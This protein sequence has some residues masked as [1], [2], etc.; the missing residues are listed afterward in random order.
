METTN[1]S[2]GDAG[3]PRRPLKLVFGKERRTEVAS[4]EPTSE[5]QGVI[6]AA[7]RISRT[8]RVLKAPTAFIPAPAAAGSGGKRRR[9]GKKATSINCAECG[10]GHSPSNNPIVLC[11][12]CESAWHKH[13]HNPQIPNGAIQNLDTEWKCNHCEPSQRSG[14]KAKFVK[15]KLVKMKLAKDPK[16][17]HK[18][19]PNSTTSAR[20]EVAGNDFTD[21]EKRAWLSGLSHSLLV[22]M[23]VDISSKNPSLPIFPANMKELPLCK[24]A[25]PSARPL[26][27]QS[28]PPSEKRT[29]DGAT[30]ID[31]RLS[32][33]R[34]N[35]AVPVATLDSM[36]SPNQQWSSSDTADESFLPTNMSGGQF[37]QDPEHS[38]TPALS[39]DAPSPYEAEL[40]TDSEG[41][42]IPFDDHRV[43]PKP[44][45][46]FALLSDPADLDILSED[47]ETKTFSHALH[48]SVARRVTGN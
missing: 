18:A 30:A 40:L 36:S 20:I 37:T 4:S 16:P 24:F 11:D 32:R 48:V 45:N 43:Y 35:S 33:T 42:D 39:S 21:T 1:I 26:S 46:G 22:E 38:T 41:G 14:I 28:A 10:R 12:G 13:C 29:H 15:G 23:L 2:S 44:G 9:G 3:R 31:S 34:S 47:P 7:T 6:T 5:A 8:G 17:A 25:V 27:A 19:E